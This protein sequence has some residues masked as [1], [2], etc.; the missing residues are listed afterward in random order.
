M[1]RQCSID[2]AHCDERSMALWS[3]IME[4]WIFDLLVEFSPVLIIIGIVLWILHTTFKGVTLMRN[5]WMSDEQRKR[6]FK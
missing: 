1:H 2:I 4:R 6:L 5:S 3:T